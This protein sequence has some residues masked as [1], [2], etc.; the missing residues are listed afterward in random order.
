MAA[1]ERALLGALDGS[2]HTP[3]GAHAVPLPGGRLRI[4][5]LVARPDGS[6][7]LRQTV[8]CLVADAARAGAALGDALRLDSPGDLFG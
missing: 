5:G 2:C 4:T 1:A 8:E 3:I 7:V 6:F